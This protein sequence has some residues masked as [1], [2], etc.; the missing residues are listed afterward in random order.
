MIQFVSSGQSIWPTLL[1]LD[2]FDV[3]SVIIHKK[4]MQI[5]GLFN[6]VKR[7]VKDKA[8][9]WIADFVRFFYLLIELQC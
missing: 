7:R 6:E 8:D 5:V 9:Y 3:S 4:S 2:Q 1:K